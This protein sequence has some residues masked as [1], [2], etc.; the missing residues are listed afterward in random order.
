M[1]DSSTPQARFIVWWP[2]PE[3]KGIP[4]ARHKLGE[5]EFL[6]ATDNAG[7]AYTTTFVVDRN[8]PQQFSRITPKGVVTKLPT[9][10][11]ASVVSVS[12]D[13]T[14]LALQLRKGEVV[15]TSIDG[16][17]KWRAP[18]HDTTAVEFSTDNKTVFAYGP[19]GA[20]SFDTASGKQLATACAW[21]FGLS[22]TPLDSQM[23]TSLAACPGEQ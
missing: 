6:I 1:F 11:D 19:A 17:E 21:L 7:N 14:L 22:D 12:P 23:L 8:N 4:N 3:Q 18:T 15:V 20:T 5:Q 9:P 10:A 2:A 13:G 16:V